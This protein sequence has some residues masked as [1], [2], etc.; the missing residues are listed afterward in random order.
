MADPYLKT[1]RA[2]EH[3]ED[4][5]GR[6]IAF[7]KSKPCTFSRQDDPENR[8]HIIRFHIREIADKVP[9]IVGDF[10]YCLRSSLDQL[11][12]ALA[13]VGGINYPDGTQFPIFS[14]PNPR[15]FGDFTVGVP[16][17]AVQII[18]H[19][20]PYHGRDSAAI[21]SH[22]LWRLNALCNIDKHRRIPTDAIVVDFD[23]PNF[24]RQY[25]PFAVFD[26]DAEITGVRGNLR[27]IGISG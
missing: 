26:H 25:L 18:D 7:E 1:A 22:L 19:L 12:W 21:Q 27:E 4:L 9:L 5:R 2:K 20:Q 14:K 16:A 11:V 17:E 10:L 6:L 8:R 23:F 15:K 24:P 3:L 13:Q